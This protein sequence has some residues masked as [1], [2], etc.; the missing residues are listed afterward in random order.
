MRPVI[1]TLKP[2]HANGRLLQTVFRDRLW[3]NVFP[4]D[5]AYW[6]N[7]HLSDTQVGQEPGINRRKQVEF[8]GPLMASAW[9]VAKSARV[10]LHL[11]GQVA[12]MASDA[13]IQHV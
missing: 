12:T 4:H 7:V 5:N 11:T 6:M 3:M 13:S 2:R 1:E 10:D 9:R 8:Q